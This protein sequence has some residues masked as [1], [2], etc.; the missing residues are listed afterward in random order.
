MAKIYRSN[1]YEVRAY[2]DSHG[3]MITHNERVE[4][5]IQDINDIVERARS[6]G[7]YND[8]KWL[9]VS[10]ETETIYDDDYVFESQ[11]TYRRAVAL[12]DN[13]VVTDL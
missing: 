10:V 1:L 3:L 6:R 9:I 11:H 2:K 4:D 13:G 5:V 12:Y 8:E 7:Y